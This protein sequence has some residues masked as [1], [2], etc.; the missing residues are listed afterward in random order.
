MLEP[1]MKSSLSGANV[2]RIVVVVFFVV[3]CLVYFYP[4]LSPAAAPDFA[5]TGFSGTDIETISQSP[6]YVQPLMVTSKNGF[7]GTVTLSLGTMT[8]ASGYTG[9]SASQMTIRLSS[10]TVTV[11]SGG[12][13]SVSIT[14]WANSAIWDT[15]ATPN[16][17]G[18]TLTLTATSGSITHTYTATGGR[19]VN[20]QPNN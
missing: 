17:P 13:T 18:Y 16:S 5:V 14:Y 7:S 2:A 10:T 3:V 1:S 12:S 19:I 8:F 9:P 4:M 6:S 15:Y 11:A 20:M